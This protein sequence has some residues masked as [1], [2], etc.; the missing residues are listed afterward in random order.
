M[1]YRSFTKRQLLALTWWN[2]PELKNYD[3]IICDGAIR[4]GKTV[5]MADVFFVW[6]MSRFQGHSFGI[7]GRSIAS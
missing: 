3:A 4:S 2:R 1:I 6:S 5:C 7:C